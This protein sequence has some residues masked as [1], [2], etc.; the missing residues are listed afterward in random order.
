[1]IDTASRAG[2]RLA[3]ESLCGIMPQVVPSVFAPKAL[4]LPPAA[5]A[6]ED[7]PSE[8]VLEEDVVVEGAA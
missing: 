6:V 3:V 7:P 8:L 5:V 2:P 4:T 1:M